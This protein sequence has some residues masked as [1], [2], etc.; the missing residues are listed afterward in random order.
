MARSVGL[1]AFLQLK[2][3]A[4]LLNDAANKLAAVASINRDFF[5]AIPFK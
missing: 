4:W 5:M 3:A 1:L 2:L